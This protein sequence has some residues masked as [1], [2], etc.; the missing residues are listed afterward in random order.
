MIPRD[1]RGALRDDL[2]AVKDD[3]RRLRADSGVLAR[4]A[5]IAGKGSAAEAKAQLNHSLKNATIRGRLGL[6]K[7]REQVGKRPGTAMAAAFG[8]GLVLGLLLLSRR[9]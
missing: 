4:D 5:F 8:V 9:A 2:T 7:A 6:R 1:N 3:L